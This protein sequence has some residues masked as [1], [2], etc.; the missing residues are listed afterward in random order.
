MHSVIHTFYR[1]KFIGCFFAIVIISFIGSN[2]DGAV[3]LLFKNS[4]PSWQHWFGTDW[5]GRDVFSRSLQAL[6]FSLMVGGVATLCST[7]ISLLLALLGNLNTTVS[8]W[9]DLTIDTLMSLPHLLL[10]ILLTLISGGGEQGVII[11]VMFSHWPRLTRLLKTEI[12]HLSDRPYIQL[13]RGFGI[14]HWQVLF[15]HVLPHL[16]PQWLT[17]ILLLYPHVLLHI[18][19]LTFIGFGLDPSTPSMGTML[20]EASRYL[21]TGHWWL[22]FFPGLILVG[23]VLLL[24]AAGNS[25]INQLRLN[26]LNIIH[27]TNKKYSHAHG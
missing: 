23:T 8:W 16:I 22:G 24:V 4:A 3:N 20:S 15:R 1:Y 25:L 27:S 21:L 18:A 6:L 2:N 7:S 14:P 11:A 12:T 19:G 5:L 9:L 13:A 17:G 26:H 10:L